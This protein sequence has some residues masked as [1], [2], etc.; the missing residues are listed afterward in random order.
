MTKRVATIAAPTWT[1]ATAAAAAGSA[2]IERPGGSAPAS[3]RQLPRL[4]DQVVTKAP[5]PFAVH[6]L[7]ARALVDAPSGDEHAVRPER[8]RAIAG[9][10]READAFG[11][12]P[13]ADAEASRARLDEQEPELCDGFRSLDD[14]DGADDVALALGDPAAF[15]L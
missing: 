6:E 5:M 15:S 2:F 4:S 10:P 3:Q 14:E 8:D 1:A 7:E 9:L 11:H 12:E 13:S